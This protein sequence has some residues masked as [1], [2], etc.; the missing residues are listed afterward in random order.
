MSWGLTGCG[1]QS[2]HEDTVFLQAGSAVLLLTIWSSGG[3]GF[4]L[5]P[6]VQLILG[7]PGSYSVPRQQ[8]SRQNPAPVRFLCPFQLNRL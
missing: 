7:S 1:S 3:K 8:A 2:Q 4:E 6:D 5:A